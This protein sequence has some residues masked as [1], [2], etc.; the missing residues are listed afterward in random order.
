MAAEQDQRKLTVVTSF[1]PRG[2]E[3]Y[4]KDFLASFREFWPRER[5]HL[6]LYLEDNIEIGPYEQVPLDDENTPAW[7][8]FYEGIVR[9]PLMCGETP[10][11]YN[12]QYDARMARK[13]FIQCD[14][15]EQYGGK[16]F[17]IDADVI[18]HSKVPEDFLDQMLPDDKLCCYLGR[19]GWMYTE[20]G[21][22][23]F[24]ADHPACAAFMNGYKRIF[25]Q[26]YVFTQPAWHDCI[27]FD[28]ARR[29]MPKEYF[30]NLAEGLP[31][32]T[33]HPFAN[34]A[35]GKYMDHRKG[36]R[37]SSRSTQSDLVVKR[38]EAYWN[39]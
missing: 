26:G 15:V 13:T 24:N 6:V 9:F 29:Q 1:S 17:W 7:R 11:G 31:H 14:A 27:A 5:V 16:V 23:G 8:Y 20:S 2:Y 39:A 38:E 10:Q 3:E 32:G 35:L 28:M 4:G 34:S 21:F 37:K 33:M 18:T 25:T 30:H 22:L 19:D 36:P 12:I